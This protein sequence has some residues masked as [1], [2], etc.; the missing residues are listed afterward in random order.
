MTSYF[1]IQTTFSMTIVYISQ[2]GINRLCF[3]TAGELTEVILEVLGTAGM[4]LFSQIGVRTTAF[5]F[6]M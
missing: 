2:L 5:L 6:F 4:W 1:G 3:G